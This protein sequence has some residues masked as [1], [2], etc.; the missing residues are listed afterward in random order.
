MTDAPETAVT[1][2]RCLD[3]AWRGRFPP[4]PQETRLGDKPQSGF[5]FEAQFVNDIAD[6]YRSD[7][8]VEVD[9][10]AYAAGA[11]IPLSRGKH[12]L[13][14]ALHTV[15]LLTTSAVLQP[16]W[17]PAPKRLFRK[18]QRGLFQR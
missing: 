18:Q 9:G 7:V 3:F 8:P 2:L 11:A 16:T 14:A 4:T 15:R 17:P 10:T 5:L 13:R 6:S 12:T 1:R